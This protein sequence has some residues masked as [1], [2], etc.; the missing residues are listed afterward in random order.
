MPKVD[1]TVTISVILGC[2][3][4][5]SP[6]ATTI[7]SSIFQYRIKK[8]ELREK[9]YQ[10]NVIYRRKIFEDY[11]RATGSCIASASS[12]SLR[13]YGR[14]YFL[15]YTYAPEEIRSL[16]SQVDQSIAASDWIEATPKFEATSSSIAQL[17]QS[18]S[19]RKQ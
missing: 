11:L 5:I 8:L 12:E 9:R 19:Q 16:M 17:L 7:I 15:A 10:E 6:I 13:D 4:V 14:S 3:A 2:A 18:L 1:L